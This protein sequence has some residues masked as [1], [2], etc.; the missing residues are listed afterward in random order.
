VIATKYAVAVSGK[1]R[2][3][4]F[5]INRLGWFPPVIEV[6]GKHLR[7]LTITVFNVIQLLIVEIIGSKME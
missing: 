3:Q 5:K 4:S 1:K 6:T 2:K 7:L